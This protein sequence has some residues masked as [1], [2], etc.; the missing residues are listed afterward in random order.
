[1]S[2][3]NVTIEEGNAKQLIILR[4]TTA[5][6][7]ISLLGSDPPTENEVIAKFLNRTGAIISTETPDSSWVERVEFDPS[8][9]TLTFVA[10]NESRTEGF[11]ADFTDFLDVFQAP[12]VGKLYWQFKRGER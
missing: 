8:A 10:T 9:E 12:S 6:E 1:M 7:V 5:N 11:P 2:T 3:T 4:N